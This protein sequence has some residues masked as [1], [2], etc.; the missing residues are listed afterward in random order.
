MANVTEITVLDAIRRLSIEAAERGEPDAARWK[1]I[2]ERLR[3]DKQSVVSLEVQVSRVL[4]RCKDQKLVAKVGEGKKSP[5]KLTPQGFS[6]LMRNLDQ[7]EDSLRFSESH[8]DGGYYSFA[9]G[10]LKGGLIR[11]HACESDFRERL[12]LRVEAFSR[13]LED[14]PDVDVMIVRKRQQTQ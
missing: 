2:V 7:L 11:D 8:A 10:P 4:K 14:F 6:E 1:A 5:Y 9:I 13:E 3:G 12:K